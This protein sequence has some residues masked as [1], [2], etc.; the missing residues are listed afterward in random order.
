MH[1]DN[2]RLNR[3]G[4]VREDFEHDRVLQKAKAIKSCMKH[5]TSSMYTWLRIIIDEADIGFCPHCRTAG[6]VDPKI[7]GR[8]FPVS[9]PDEKSPVP[10]L[11]PKSKSPD[12]GPEAE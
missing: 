6:N 2:G 8:T 3:E 4:C 12:F 1:R 7:P 9:Y 11:S 10:S 5:L